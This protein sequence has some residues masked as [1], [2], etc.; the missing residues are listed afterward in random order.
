MALSNYERMIRIAEE[1]FATRTDP[2]QLDVDEKV[3]A[4][5]QEIHP[6]TVSEY[7][8]GN[9]PCVWIL[10]IPTSTKLMQEFLEKKITEKMLYER[11]PLHTT[12]EAIYLCSAM[13]LD[14]YRSKG[15]ATRLT[16]DAINAIAKENTVKALF[17]WP[18]SKEGDRLA[19][20]ISGLTHL[21]L[22]KR[23]V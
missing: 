8:E 12:Y 13:V 11:T 17:V 23:S 10:V 14:E 18:F 6:S 2:E 1:V 4:H 3:I 19:E 15:I 5:L 21:P 9:G 7:N 20:K 16:V 22:L